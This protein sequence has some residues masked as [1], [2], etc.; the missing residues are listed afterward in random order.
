VSRAG[1]SVKASEKGDSSSGVFSIGVASITSFG[2]WKSLGSVKG[3]I[4]HLIFTAKQ[5]L[6]ESN[7]Q[8]KVRLKRNFRPE[9]EEEVPESNNRTGEGTKGEGVV[10]CWPKETFRHPPTF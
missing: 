10:A 8:E 5:K 2:A 3:R 9:R 7:H 6:I 1:S 4:E